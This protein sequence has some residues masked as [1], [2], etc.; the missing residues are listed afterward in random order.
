MKV[1]PLV[2]AIA[3]RRSLKSLSFSVTSCEDLKSEKFVVAK[4]A[5]RSINRL[6]VRPIC[7][8]PPLKAVHWSH[9][10]YAVSVQLFVDVIYR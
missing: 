9:R 3:D 6:E 4:D 8:F 5:L 1:D 7:I 10:E 2:A